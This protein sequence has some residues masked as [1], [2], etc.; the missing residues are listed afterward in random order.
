VAGFVRRY[1]L[2]LLEEFYMKRIP[3]LI[4]IAGIFLCTGR[5]AAQEDPPAGFIRDL[6]GDVEIK[7]PGSTVWLPAKRGS[8]V[9]GKTVIST[10]FKSTAVI[11]LGNSTLLV[12][13]LTRLS[14]EDIHRTIE[15][16][17]VILNL[18]TGRVRVRVNPPPGGISNFTV[19]SSSAT[20]SVRGTV[21]DFDTVNLRVEE[22]TVLFF[23][24][25]GRPA[26]VRAGGTSVVDESRGRAAGARE[27]AAAELTPDLPAGSDSGA[28]LE[29]F[30]GG[31]V[32][33]GMVDFSV[34]L[35]W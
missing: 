23:G 24:D 4:V 11:S 1:D 6:S 28:A 34:D 14:L 27:T 18:Q 20:A 12:R 3:V 32:P 26:A 7:A 13:P 9:T 17:K 8:P 33:D 15:E 5:V 22:G 31:K 19:K 25:D 30:V 10:G 21:F 16:E 35:G 2:A 29:E